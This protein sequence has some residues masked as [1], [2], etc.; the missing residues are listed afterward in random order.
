[1]VQKYSGTKKTLLEIQAYEDSWGAQ[2]FQKVQ[3]EK[4]RSTYHTD[5]DIRA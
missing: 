2:N 3:R 4:E 5:P 1:M